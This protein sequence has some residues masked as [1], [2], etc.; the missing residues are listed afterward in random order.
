MEF[1]EQDMHKGHAT[2]Q[3]VCR[4]PLTT[5]SQVCSWGSPRGICGG[6]SG[7]G[8]D[9]PASSSVF[10]CQYHSTVALHFHMS[11]SSGRWK[12]GLL[13]TAV[14]RHSLAPLTWT[15]HAHACTCSHTH[16]HTQGL[17]FCN[18]VSIMIFHRRLAN[19]GWMTFL[20]Y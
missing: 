10:P 1:Y 15:R 18:D 6:Q 3:A 8:T 9:F 11:I 19:K 4:Q 16:T 5:E 7:T 14:Q 13:E 17:K 12:T 2:A 20:Y